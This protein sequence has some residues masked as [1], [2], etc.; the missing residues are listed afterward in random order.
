MHELDSF[1]SPL[2]S[3]DQSPIGF[4]LWYGNVYVG[5]LT[6]DP[7][8]GVWQFAYTSEFKAWSAD[9]RVRP[10]FE[11]PDLDRIYSSKELWSSFRLRI[12]SLK[13][14]EIAKEVEKK[15]INPNDIPSLLRLFGR[16]TVSDPYELIPA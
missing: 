8:T 5:D 14:D 4:R 10:L 15:H 12:P 1:H 9:Q 16:R 13:R 2:W 6:F 11:F 3:A 7:K